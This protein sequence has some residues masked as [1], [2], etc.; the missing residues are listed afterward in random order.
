MRKLGNR[1]NH[2]GVHSCRAIAAMLFISS[3][4]RSQ[5]FVPSA[6]FLEYGRVH[7]NSSTQRCSIESRELRFHKSNNASQSH[8]QFYNPQR[9]QSFFSSNEP[10]AFSVSRS[11]LRVATIADGYALLSKNSF[12]SSTAWDHRG[13]AI[14]ATAAYLSLT[15]S[16]A[17]IG[18]VGTGPMIQL[19]QQEAE[20]F[21]ILIKAVN[22]LGLDCTLRVAGGWVR[23][24]LLATEE[25]QRG[26][27]KRTDDN[28]TNVAVQ[29]L[30]SKYKG[31]S[32]GRMGTKLIGLPKTV[33]EEDIQSTI[34]P[35]LSLVNKQN[36]QPVDIDIALDNM[37]GR[38]FAEKFN[39]WLS[40]N[41]RET[42]SVGMIDWFFSKNLVSMPVYVFLF[43]FVSHK[44]HF[45]S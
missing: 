21:E 10:N 15:T 40:L 1:R 36:Q 2:R 16:A 42:H 30:T 32:A 31:P 34:T 41:G 33:P 38:E 11:S 20:L 3:T 39:S 18:R 27:S 7:G 14:P 37:L 45:F 22:T 12:S 25:F 19:T 23:D 28:N 26:S 35:F 6:R 43:L 44:S 5:G 29:R 17:H 4:C 13:G 8:R 24:K 9:Y